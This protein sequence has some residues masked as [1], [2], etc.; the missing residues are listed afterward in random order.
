MKIKQ[1]QN[2]RQ[3]VRGKERISL[4]QRNEWLSVNLYLSVR[5]ILVSLLF[6]ISLAFPLV[7][8]SW[9]YVTWHAKK[10]KS[11]SYLFFIGKRTADISR[12]SLK[13]MNTERKRIYI[14]DKKNKKNGALKYFYQNSHNITLCTLNL[15][16]FFSGY[17]VNK[18]RHLIAMA[19]LMI[20]FFYQ[21]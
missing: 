8:L 3:N 1:K 10:K 18:G 5:T 4:R 20:Y 21:T 13:S 6:F 12:D 17:H 14:Y 9:L 15:F 7:S 16:L 19:F 2:Q 11:V